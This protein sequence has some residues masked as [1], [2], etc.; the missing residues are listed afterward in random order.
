[1]KKL[2]A[3]L[4][5]IRIVRK[6]WRMRRRSSNSWSEADEVILQCSPML[7]DILD[8]VSFQEAMWRL[9]ER[10]NGKKPR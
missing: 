2:M 8:E 5:R 1:M 9:E 6:L 4:M 3:K 10:L 7:K